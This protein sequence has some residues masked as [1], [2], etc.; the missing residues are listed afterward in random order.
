MATAAT[1]RPD[2][3]ATTWMVTR[4]VLI[5]NKFRRAAF[6]LR[7]MRVTSGV[8]WWC[9]SSAIVSGQM[10]ES[11]LIRRRLQG[12]QPERAR[13]GDH[14]QAAAARIREQGSHPRRADDA[15]PDTD[16][17][18]SRHPQI[19]DRQYPRGFAACQSCCG[20]VHDQGPMPWAIQ[21]RYIS[22]KIALGIGP[23]RPPDALPGT[24]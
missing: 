9:L 6:M 11:K 18:E 8:N 5:S 16:T 13:G 21:L 12:G 14:Q 1:W 20:A 3:R 4:F 23:F 24:G 17:W 10:P 7:K 19:V 2:R 15:V 22:D